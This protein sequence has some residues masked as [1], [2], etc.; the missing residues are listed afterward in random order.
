MGSYERPLVLLSPEFTFRP[1]RLAAPDPTVCKRDA[2]LAHPVT[3]VTVREALPLVGTALHT[4]G[5]HGPLR[6]RSDGGPGGSLACHLRGAGLRRGHRRLLRRAERAL[7]SQQQ[8]RAQQQ[9]AGG[10]PGEEEASHV[11]TICNGTA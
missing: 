1:P 9:G 11:P 8:P 6:R 4:P 2:A 10:L 7:R 3:A 5:V